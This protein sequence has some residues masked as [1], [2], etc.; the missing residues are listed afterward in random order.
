MSSLD[1]IGRYYP[2]T[3]FACAT[4]GNAIA[5]PDIDAHDQWFT[6]VED[7]LLSTL[8]NKVAFERIT[9]ALEQL[10]APAEH[11]RDSQPEGL[12]ILKNGIVA[13]P[14]GNRSFSDLFALL[15]TANHSNL[16]ATASFWWTVGGRDFDPFAFCCQRLPDPSLFTNMITGR[17]NSAAT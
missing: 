7:F 10:A 15:R 6:A 16:Y 8:D 1:G 4:P 3:L 11:P 9:D 17:I 14:L 2:L 13:G 5:P 12:W